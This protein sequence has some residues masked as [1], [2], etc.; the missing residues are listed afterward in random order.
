MHNEYPSSQSQPSEPDLQE[1]LEKALKP[2]LTALLNEKKKTYFNV[3]TTFEQ[4]AEK[5]KQ[6]YLARNTDHMQ[7][8]IN[9]IRLLSERFKK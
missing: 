3:F 6:S 9:G 5:L 1:D 8:L 4:H 2:L 7:R